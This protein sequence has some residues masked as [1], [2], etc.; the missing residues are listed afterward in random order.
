L[1]HD[2]RQKLLPAI[3]KEMFAT[4]RQQFQAKDTARAEAG[5]MAVL[6]LTDDPAWK[7][8]SEAADLR[9]LASGFADLSK[10]AAA[11]AAQAPPVPTPPP[12]PRTTVFEAPVV[13]SQPLPRWVAPDITS[14]HREYRGQVKVLIGTDG[15]VKS[16]TIQTPTHPSYDQ[17]VL[18]AA[19][20]W[21]YKPA[22]RNGEPVEAEK[23]VV[24]YLKGT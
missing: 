17:Q 15:K 18:T 20:S 13:I 24:V 11:A 3:A 6:A 14:A 5:F 10:A 16:A 23:I 7:A 8:S 21:L 12:A 19:R 2:A 1:V 22:L 4:A 9:V